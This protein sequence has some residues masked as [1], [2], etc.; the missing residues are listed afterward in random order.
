MKNKEFEDTFKEE[1]KALK[2]KI[3]GKD[4]LFY[5]QLIARAKIFEKYQQ[6][7]AFYAMHALGEYLHPKQIEALDAISNNRKV[8][9]F[10][11]HGYGKTRNGAVIARWF[12]DCFPHSRVITTAPTGQQVKNLLWKEIH[13]L[14][15]TGRIA[16]DYVINEL[17][18]KESPTKIGTD[19]KHLLY[20]FSTDKPV[21]LEGA[22]GN[23]YLAIIDEAKGFKEEL[24]RAIKGSLT[25]KKSKVIMLSTTDGTEPGSLF[26]QIADGDPKFQDW[27]R[28]KTTIY[29]LPEYTK[30]DWLGIEWLDSEGLYWRYVRKKYDELDFPISGELW[31]KECED[32]WGIES[33]LYKSKVLAELVDIKEE[34]IIKGMHFEKMWANY[35]EVDLEKLE[36]KKVLGLDPAGEGQDYIAMWYRVGNVFLKGMKFHVKPVMI[37][38][39]AGERSKFDDGTTHQIC[40][41]VEAFIQYDKAVEIRVDRS[42]LGEGVYSELRARG[43]RAIGIYFNGKSGSPLY[44]DKIT[45]MFFELK[46]NHVKFAMPKN[47]QSRET[48]R[49]L[50]GRRIGGVKYTGIHE[51]LYV[52]PKPVYKKRNDGKSPDLSD[53]Y[54]MCAYE[55]ETRKVDNSRVAVV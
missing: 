47:E 37:T 7:A 19:P 4:D 12:Y 6:D 15:L 51:A 30:A 52:E 11:C 10:G 24:W 23:Y 49:Q 2:K 53:A 8:V 28:V 20:G 38:N 18:V 46:K 13:E 39:E 25:T 33:P 48:M 17:E 35:R 31:R 44:A 34:S 42:G 26:Y 1:I 3:P 16:N 41:T 55:S 43:Y 40:D 54:L 21:R 36:G 50:C 27:V 32:E 45:E 14:Y 9:I 5:C 22:H 29:D